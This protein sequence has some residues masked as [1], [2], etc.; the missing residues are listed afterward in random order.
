MNLIY[1]ANILH[2]E[3]T[4]PLWL[5]LAIVL[6]LI[7]AQIVNALVMTGSPTRD[8]SLLPPLIGRGSGRPRPNF[9]N[10]QAKEIP[11]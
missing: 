7:V 6:S 2:I 9:D 10:E 5:V 3:P 1:S 4:V 8:G 11:R